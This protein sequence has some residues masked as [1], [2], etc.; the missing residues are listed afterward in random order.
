MFS[1]NES[2]NKIRVIPYVYEADGGRVVDNFRNIFLTLPLM[3]WIQ[4]LYTTPTW[5]AW[6]VVP[7]NQDLLHINLLLNEIRPFLSYVHFA[8]SKSR[9]SPK[10]SFIFMIL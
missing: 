7:C 6:L 10:L 8:S 9:F 2:T 5:S 1:Q 4:I 3:K